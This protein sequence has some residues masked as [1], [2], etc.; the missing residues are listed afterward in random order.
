MIYGFLFVVF[1][2]AAEEIGPPIIALAGYLI[3]YFLIAFFTALRF[4]GK[5]LLWL[6]IRIGK[7]A[8]RACALAGRGIH[9]SALLLYFLIDEKLRGE[10]D[11]GPEEEWDD[12]WDDEPEDPAEIIQSETAYEAAL[13]TLGLEPGVTRDVLNKTY[14][15][16]MVKV[17]PDMPGGS[18]RAAQALNISRDLVMNWNG[19]A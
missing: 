14:K 7:G 15:Q 10:Q 6:I 12:D 17:H 13:A 1:L 9:F 3:W 11:E 18:T 4:T 8:G 19:W 5:G 16:M 2:L